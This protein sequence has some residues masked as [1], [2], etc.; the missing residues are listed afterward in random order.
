[1][2]VGLGVTDSQLCEIFL[3]RGV[4]PGPEGSM[5]Q[6]WKCSL[7]PPRPGDLEGLPVDSDPGHSS[8]TFPSTVPGP[9]RV[10]ISLP[11]RC[12]G[13]R[14]TLHRVPLWQSRRAVPGHWRGRGLAWLRPPP[15]HVVIVGIQGRRD[16]LPQPPELACRALC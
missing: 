13:S 8:R 10:P 6:A 2:P 15:A 5:R 4:S 12:P 16:G 7:S 9:P 1:M 3:G 14:G 11:A